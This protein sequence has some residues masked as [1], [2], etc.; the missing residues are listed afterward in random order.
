MIR[1]SYR[2]IDRRE[3]HAPGGNYVK[4]DVVHIFGID[5]VTDDFVNFLQYIISC[6]FL[7]VVHVGF[8]AK[9]LSNGMKFLLNSEPL[10]MITLR[11]LEYI[12]IHTSLNI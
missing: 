4:R 6:G 1:A 5:N 2:K 10:S 7:I 12:D 3:N 8:K 11:G 9:Y